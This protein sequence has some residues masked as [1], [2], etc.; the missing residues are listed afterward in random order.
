[1]PRVD[2]RCA[3]CGAT[4]PREDFEV[5]PCQT[6]GERRLFC[7]TYCKANV[8]MVRVTLRCADCKA[9]DERV[10]APGRRRD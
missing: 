8:P 5:A 7:R 10:S 2:Y 9:V 6:C 3:R 4:G 1:M